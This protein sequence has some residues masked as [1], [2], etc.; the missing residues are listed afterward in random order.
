MVAHTLWIDPAPAAAHGI[1]V[2]Y[3]PINAG[4]DIRDGEGDK[5]TLHTTETGATLAIANMLISS[6]TYEP[7]RGLPHFLVG[8]N[9]LWQFLPLNVGGYTLENSPG[10]ADTNRS[11]PNIQAEIMSFA[12]E[13]W[14]DAT[15]ETVGYMLAATKKAGHDFDIEKYPRFWGAN[16]GIILARY[17]SPLRMGA[18]EFI[19][20]NGWTD[21]NHTPENAHWDIGKKNGKRIHD[22]AYKYLNL[23]GEDDMTPEEYVA[24]TTPM[25]NA[26]GDRIVKALQETIAAN[27]D[28]WMGVDERDNKLYTV[29]HGMKTYVEPVRKP[30]GSVDDAA[31]SNR[32]QDLIRMGYDF[33]GNQGA[34]LVDL[35]VFPLR[36]A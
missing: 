24:A 10:G 20:Y 2:I 17:D 8:P 19:D 6:W 31:T 28:K 5:F 33:R 11:G 29:L 14:D 27:D 4:L 30:D 3:H 34:L 9:L 7:G 15:Y 21:H 23:N 32:I 35:P 25:F 36:Y 13:D 12:A 18:Q 26:L 16:E 1:E 22:I